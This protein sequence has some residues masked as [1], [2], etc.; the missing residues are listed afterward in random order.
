MSSGDILICID[1]KSEH[2]LE[3]CE[4]ESIEADFDTE[5]VHI[6]IRH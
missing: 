2:Y 4:I 1:E 3:V 5:I 6:K